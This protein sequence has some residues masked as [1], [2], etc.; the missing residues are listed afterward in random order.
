LVQLVFLAEVEDD[1]PAVLEGVSEVD[2]VEQEVAYGVKD[3]ILG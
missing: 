2:E 3:D 1:F